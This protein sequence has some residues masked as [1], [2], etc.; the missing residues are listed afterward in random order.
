MHI[1]ECIYSVS[2]RDMHSYS[3]TYSFVS[4]PG[5]LSISQSA[6]PVS[7]FTVFPHLRTF[8]VFSS[9]LNV[10]KGRKKDFRNFW[11]RIW[12][13]VPSCCPASQNGCAV[14]AYFCIDKNSRVESIKVKPANVFDFKNQQQCYFRYLSA[15]FVH[16]SVVGDLFYEWLRKFVRVPISP[17]FLGTISSNSS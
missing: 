2:S 6:F 5:V 12:H 9:C 11:I 8:R 1:K 14:V 4:I 3:D 16:N 17:E 7:S 13:H 15:S 10:I